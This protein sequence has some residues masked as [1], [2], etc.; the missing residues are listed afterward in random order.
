MAP[1]KN[2]HR[3]PDKV[4]G[5]FNEGGLFGE[6]KGWHLPEFDTSSW[7]TQDDLLLTTAGVGFFV[8]TI[9]LDLP[10]NT[11]VFLSLT[12]EEPFGQPYRA[13]LFVN[14]WMM[15]KRVGNLGYVYE[16]VIMLILSAVIRPQAK[17][18]VHEGIFDYHG[19][20][21]VFMSGYFRMKPDLCFRSTLAVALWNMADEAVTPNL[22]LTLDGFVDGGV[23]GVDTNNSPWSSDGRA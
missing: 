4:R 13:I 14:G 1:L 21:C 15:G 5:V 22:Q 18:P 17:F 16:L 19:T 11:D 7:D 2:Q 6:R 10:E 3:Y 20:K 8:T 23:G 9:D 12:F